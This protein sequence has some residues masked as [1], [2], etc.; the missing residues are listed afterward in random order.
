MWII[1]RLPEHI[2]NRL[3][4]GEIV[5]RPASIVKELME[6]SLDAWATS[7][8]L[9]VF[10]GGK[11]RIMLRD[12]GSWMSEEDLSMTI[13]RFATSKITSDEDLQS[14]SSY[15]FRWEALASIAEVSNVT[16]QTKVEKD[17]IGY[18]LNKRDNDL[19]SKKL[20]T[21]FEHWTTVIIED[22]FY[23]VPARSK[24]LKSNQTEYYYIYQL[25]INY[26][27]IHRD[28]HFALTKQ[29]KQIF[30]LSPAKD[31]LERIQELFRKDR[32]TNLRVVDF[33]D[34]GHR[35]YGV[36]WDPSLRFGSQEHI[37]LFVNKRPV[38][39]RVIKRALLD[40]YRRQLPQGDYPLAILFFDIDPTKV[41]VNVH[42]R[43]NEV[44]FLDPGSIFQL[45]KSQIQLAIWTQQMVA[46][47]HEDVSYGTQNSF[48]SEWNTTKLF[49]ATMQS[50]NVSSQRENDTAWFTSSQNESIVWIARFSP[51]QYMVGDY[52][53]IGQLWNSYIILQDPDYVYYIDQH[54]L[55]ERILYEKM[56]SNA[57][58]NEFIPEPLLQPVSIKLAQTIPLDEKIRELSQRWFDVH[59]ISDNAIAIYAVPKFLQVFIIDFE[60]LFQK[61]LYSEQEI[62]FGRILE[63]IFATKACKAAIKAWQKLSYQEMKHLIEDGFETITQFFVCQHGRPFFIKIE[64]KGIEKLFD[65]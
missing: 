7:L 62:T 46:A 40:A 26:A 52:E 13:E 10:D 19:Y 65:R 16:I 1:K 9:Y 21:G 43:K 8:D 17:V 31:L 49:N 57:I 33:A 23:N 34:E 29:W 28:K 58:D 2:I 4:A 30:Q 60:L 24:F 18:Q 39:D 45:I 12:N 50:S 14:I 11:K 64:K 35:L 22:L 41:D 47:S 32:S 25:F 48:Q 53:L 42:P 56:K 5:E 6:N 55:A 15:G 63:E 51:E 54:A 61:I 38:S 59:A 20:A 3:K 27:I 44:K 36:V 37:K